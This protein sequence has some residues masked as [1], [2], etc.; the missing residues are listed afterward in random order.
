MSHAAASLKKHLLHTSAM[1]REEENAKKRREGGWD[2]WY[3]DCL[4]PPH[5]H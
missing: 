4:I 5:L 3:R 1:S 2:S